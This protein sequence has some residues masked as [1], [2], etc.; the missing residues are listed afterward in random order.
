ML[1]KL[2]KGLQDDGNEDIEYDKGKHNALKEEDH[3]PVG[4]KLVSIEPDFVT[5][6]V[7]CVHNCKEV[8]NVKFGL[9]LIIAKLNL[10]ELGVN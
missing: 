8:S 3:V 7:H 6:I 4:A 10:G 5:Y 1:F 2:I 9:L